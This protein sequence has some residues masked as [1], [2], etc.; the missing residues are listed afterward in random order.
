MKWLFLLLLIINLGI[1]AWGYQREQV[2]QSSLI[3][4][5]SDVG[6][7]RM[8]EEMVQGSEPLEPEIS[9]EQ[10]QEQE[11]EPEV[12]VLET[13][14]ETATGSGETVEVAAVDI[15]AAEPAEEQPSNI[16]IEAD[17]EPKSQPQA[18]TDTTSEIATDSGV[19]AETKNEDAREVTTIAEAQVDTT[20]VD[21]AEATPEPQVASVDRDISQP[22]VESPVADDKPVPTKPEITSRCGRIGPIKDRKVAKQVLGELKKSKFEAKLERS[23]EKLQIGYWVVIPPLSDGSQAQAKID[24]LSKAGLKDI[25]HFRGGGLKNAISL[26][27]FS[28]KENAENYS[29]ELLRKGFRT[30]MQPRTINKTSYL[31]NF[32]ITKP[33]SV[34]RLMWRMAE[35]K[36]SKM[37]FTEQSCES[38]ASR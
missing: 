6:D 25:W 1:F 30:K 34:T 35:R 31:V 28:K 29:Q 18:E 4:A 13:E 21:E 7:M 20:P 32:S 9:P 14:A 2:E 23:V 16:E 3:A 26:G 11:Q 17:S 37:P 15:A 22:D 38:I 10:E 24:E 27:M 36:Y 8:L 12:A 33:K 19:V 5:G